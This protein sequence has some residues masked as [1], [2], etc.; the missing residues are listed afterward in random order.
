MFVLFE[1][2][3]GYALFRLKN[4][5][6]ANTTEKKVQAEI[7]DFATFS[8][9]AQLTVP[10]HSRRAS[11]LS[12]PPTSPSKSSTRPSLARPP[13]RSSLSSLRTSPSRKNPRSSWV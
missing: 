6:D 13:K 1:S 8:T 3:L 9:I 11:T 12:S 2:S 10:L 4:F 7:A 5:D